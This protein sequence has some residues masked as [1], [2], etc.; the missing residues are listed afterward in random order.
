M[1][2][3][4][5]SPLQ[6]S[7]RQ[8][9]GQPVWEQPPRLTGETEVQGQGARASF[10]GA[11]LPQQPAFLHG[12]QALTLPREVPSGSLWPGI[13]PEEEGGSACGLLLNFTLS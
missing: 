3:L 12:Q 2:G 11:A 9:D 8:L 10:S 1:G 7:L 6:G 5:G 13:W 4:S